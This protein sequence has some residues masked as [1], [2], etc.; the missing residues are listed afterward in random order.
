M[1]ASRQFIT[2]PRRMNLGEF[3]TNVTC[4]QDF[5]DIFLSNWFLVLQTFWRLIFGKG[6][7]DD[8]ST[9]TRSNTGGGG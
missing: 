3:E 1:M 7:N 9:V 5:V 8:S 4:L 2:K 6:C